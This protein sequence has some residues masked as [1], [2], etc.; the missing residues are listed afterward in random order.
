MYASERFEYFKGHLEN[1]EL[2]F[3]LTDKHIY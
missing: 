2:T 3:L 1:I